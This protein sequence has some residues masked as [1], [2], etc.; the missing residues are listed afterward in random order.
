MANTHSTVNQA[1]ASP[2][3]EFWYNVSPQDELP[4]AG[5][6][7]RD[8]DIASAK[9]FFVEITHARTKEEAVPKAARI[10]RSDPGLFS[11][12]RQFIGVSDKRAYLDLS[13]RASRAAHPRS[14]S[15]LCGC[16]PW[17]LSKHPVSFFTG[18]ASGNHGEDVADAM[19]LLLADYLIEH[20]IFEGAKGFADMED[21]VL[22]GL[23][24]G[25]I[26]PKEYQQKAA[27]RRGHGCEAALA[28]V[29]TSLGVDLVPNDKARNPLGSRDPNVDL[30]TMQIVE[31]AA[32]TT[33]SFDMIIRNQNEVAIAIQALIHT[34]DP[35]QYGVNKS[36][37]TVEVAKTIKQW[38]AANPGHP[39]ELWGL[40]D[41]VGFCE[42]KPDT[43]NKMLRWFDTF[44]Q[45]KTLYKAPLR[46]HRLGIISLKAIRFSDAY[47]AADIQAISNLYVPG[48][49]HVLE[50]GDSVDARS[51]A[52]Q[53]GL[54]VVYI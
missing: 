54:A 39:V 27:K 41:G 32:G 2:E 24:T 20:G 49:V 22:E 4:L 52:I 15:G 12:I 34:S 37:E 30:S 40:V 28:R 16:Y 50:Q 25:L 47:S 23:Y 8:I 18:M 11:T 6:V 17:A 48:G 51:I 19:A 1:Y 43:I 29:L 35:G 9:E 36:N 38:R 21:E 14:D 26:S 45:I 13:Y 46:L 44:I 31:R 42:N 53:A 7:D 33:Y 10:L 5:T 3:E